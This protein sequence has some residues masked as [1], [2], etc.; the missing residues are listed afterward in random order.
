MNELEA[1]REMN[2]ESKGLQKKGS[3]SI[4]KPASASEMDVVRE[5]LKSGNQTKTAAVLGL[6]SRTVNTHLMTV[7]RKF[8]AENVVDFIICCIRRGLI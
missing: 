2:A 1:Q 8:G 7:R 6:N 3:D 5:W 4:F